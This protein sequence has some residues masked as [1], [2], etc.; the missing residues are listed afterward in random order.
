LLSEH[1]ADYLTFDRP[2]VGSAIWATYRQGIS[3][4]AVAKNAAKLGLRISD[5]SNYFFQPNVSKLRDFIRMG[6]CSL[7]ENEMAA[8][9][10]IWKQALTPFTKNYK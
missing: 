5:G 6:Y 9:I 4:S 1:L 7:N 8:A 10:D 2:N 3:A